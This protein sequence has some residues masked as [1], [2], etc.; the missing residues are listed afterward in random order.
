MTLYIYPKKSCVWFPAKKY[1]SLF[2]CEAFCFSIFHIFFYTHQAFVFHLLGDF[3]IACNH[4]LT[5]VS[6]TQKD[7]DT[8][9]ELFCE[10]FLAFFC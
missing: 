2:I 7:I 3:Y 1:Q 9:L 10:T 6:L 8:F 5:F 4:I